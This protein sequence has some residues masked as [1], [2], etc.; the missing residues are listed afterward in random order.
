M[1]SP[2]TPGPQSELEDPIVAG[3]ANPSNAAPSWE[4]KYGQ[5]VNRTLSLAELRAVVDGWLSWP[6][7]PDGYPGPAFTFAYLEG[8]EGGGSKGHAYT[9]TSRRKRKHGNEHCPNSTLT[10]PGGGARC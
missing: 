3:L 5:Y 7:Y 8:Y 1:T 6:A 10:T 2:L 4:L 9:E